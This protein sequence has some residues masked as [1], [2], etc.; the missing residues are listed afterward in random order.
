LFGVGMMEADVR[1]QRR[2]IE[3]WKLHDLCNVHRAFFWKIC[4]DI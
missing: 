3:I 2:F 1:P 4:A